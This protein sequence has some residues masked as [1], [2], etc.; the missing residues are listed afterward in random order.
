MAGMLSVPILFELC[1]KASVSSMD[2][3]KAKDLQHLGDDW[4]CIA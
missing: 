3:T 2:E 1:K 4:A